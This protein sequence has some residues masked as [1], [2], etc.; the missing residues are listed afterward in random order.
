MVGIGLSTEEALRAGTTAAAALLGL[1][2]VEAVAGAGAGGV[3]SGV[4]GGGGAAAGGET[5]G[6]AS[7]AAGG[8]ALVGRVAPGYAADLVLFEGDLSRVG[9]SE[10]RWR[11]SQVYR[12]GVRKR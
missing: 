1:D 8:L 4:A 2:S 9:L 11:V 12:G 3:P 5:G 6:G 10:A 7:A